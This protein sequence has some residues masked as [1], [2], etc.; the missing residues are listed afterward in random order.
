M[1]K[2]LL[3]SLLFVF[4]PVAY[5]Q[6]SSSADYHPQ[7]VRTITKAKH[8]YKDK[9]FWIGV[10]INAGANA[11]DTIS[12]CSAFQR[13]YVEGEFILRG[14][15]SCQKIAVADSIEFALFTSGQAFMWHCAYNTGFHCTGMNHDPG[16]HEK[17]YGNFERWTIP[18]A[19]LASHVPAAVH[20]WRQP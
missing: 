18:V 4:V 11:M 5:A 9:Y 10:A 14:T 12:T 8:W 2:L 6:E 13:G 1:R 15:R 3:L 16:P 19:S 20:N 17:L 7:L